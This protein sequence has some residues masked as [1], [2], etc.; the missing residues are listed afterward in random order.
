VNY[1]TKF[2]E[3]YW[4]SKEDAEAFLAQ[5]EKAEACKVEWEKAHK[6]FL[7]AISQED[8]ERAALVALGKKQANPPVREPKFGDVYVTKDTGDTRYILNDAAG[9]LCMF[10]YSQV[11]ASQF[12]LGLDYFKDNSKS[13]EYIGNLFDMESSGRQGDK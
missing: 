9:E 12:D 3:G 11:S 2:S 6:Q 1:L 13:Y 4:H 5:Y 10:G 7:D 8:V